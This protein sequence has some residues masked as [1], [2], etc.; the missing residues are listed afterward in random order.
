MKENDARSQAVN[1]KQ[2]KFPVHTLFIN[3]RG[4]NRLMTVQ[5][6]HSWI[7]GERVQK[8]VKET[9]GGSNKLYTSRTK[10]QRST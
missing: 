2:S 9:E 3:R 1:P 8:V 4:P 10:V 5:G 6:R 7:F